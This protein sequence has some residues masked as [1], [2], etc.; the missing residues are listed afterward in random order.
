MPDGPAWERF[1]MNLQFGVFPSPEAD[2][3]EEVLALARIADQ[4]LALIGIQDHPGRSGWLRCE[5]SK[6]R[7]HRPLSVLRWWV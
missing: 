3:V 2:G 4:G 6:P 7:N 5:A 1:E